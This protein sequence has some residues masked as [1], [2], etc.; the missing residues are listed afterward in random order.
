MVWY[1]KP[2]VRHQVE[3]LVGGLYIDRTERVLPILPHPVAGLMRRLHS[4]EPAYQ[5]PR[6]FEVS[7]GPQNK[8]DL[9][10]LS[11]LQFKTNLE[12]CGRIETNADAARQSRPVKRRRVGKRTVPADEFRPVPAH[13]PNGFTDVE[14]HDAAREIGVERVAGKEG[15]CFGIDPRAHMHLHLRPALAEHQL[16]E[17]RCRHPA[18]DRCVI[19]DFQHPELDRRFRIHV[20][21]Q[22]ALEMRYCEYSK[23]L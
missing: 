12:R 21:P 16:H 18:V 3:R 2:A 1:N 6:V 10:F 20:D 15:A 22:F 23:T 11:R 8:N 4:A 17:P 5:A 7:P 13:V 9:L 19:A 14:K